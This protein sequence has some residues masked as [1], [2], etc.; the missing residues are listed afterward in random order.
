MHKCTGLYTS[1]GKG[2]SISFL[3]R[4]LT[5]HGTSRIEKKCL[6]FRLK[7]HPLVI[8]DVAMTYG[9]ASYS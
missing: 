4:E 9:C 8:F 7:P 1:T 5:R 6:V 2:T 3:P